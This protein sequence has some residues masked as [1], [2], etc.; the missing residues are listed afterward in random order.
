MKIKR[1]IDKDGKLKLITSYEYKALNLERKYMLVDTESKLPYFYQNEKSLIKIERICDGIP[2]DDNM[3]I[4]RDY[5]LNC[6]I[7]NKNIRKA[8]IFNLSY[9][10][11]FKIFIRIKKR[12]K[13]VNCCEW[14]RYQEDEVSL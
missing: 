6:Y 11:F 12:Y 14:L 3:K 10:L 13:F 8:H 1:I 4:A 7:F 9:M 2:C 5:M